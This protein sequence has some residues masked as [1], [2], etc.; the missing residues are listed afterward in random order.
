VV[1]KIKT[2]ILNFICK[3][4]FYVIPSFE[5]MTIYIVL[6][7]FQCHS[8]RIKCGINSSREHSTVIPANAG[9]QKIFKSSWIPS[10]E[11][12]TMMVLFLTIIIIAT[13]VKHLTSK[14]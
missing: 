9:I 3:P 5:G 13:L 1:P 11:G 6:F 8:R 10:F 4:F 14:M 2:I 7:L 12:M